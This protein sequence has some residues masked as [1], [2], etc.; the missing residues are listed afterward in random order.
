MTNA[1]LITD[2]HKTSQQTKEKSSKA[3]PRHLPILKLTIA[4]HS[5]ENSELEIQG[6][7]ILLPSSAARLQIKAMSDYLFPTSLQKMLISQRVQRPLECQ[8][9]C[10][11]RKGMVISD[12]SGSA[13]QEV[14]HSV[15]NTLLAHGSGYAAPFCNKK[16]AEEDPNFLWLL[17][18]RP[19]N[20][21]YN[22]KLES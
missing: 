14:L 18:P 6:S 16:V 7:W 17:R 1:F 12:N 13:P 10:Q 22:T 9:C 21:L 11:K 4:V 8:L 15:T 3:W 20:I 5:T 19:V 2:I